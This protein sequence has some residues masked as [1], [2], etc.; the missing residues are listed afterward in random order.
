[1][2]GD[3]MRSDFYKTSF[4]IGDE[5]LLSSCI[6]A[7]TGTGYEDTNKFNSKSSTGIVKVKFEPTFGSDYTVISPYSC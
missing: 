6:V 2:S 5:T 7:L 1:M 3:I 4:T